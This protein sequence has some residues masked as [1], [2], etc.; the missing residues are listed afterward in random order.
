M[1]RQNQCG[2]LDDNE[3][4]KNLNTEYT[5]YRETETIKGTLYHRHIDRVYCDELFNGNKKL[6]SIWSSRN[7]LGEYTKSYD[8]SDE[9]YTDIVSSLRDI[10][11]LVNVVQI[12]LT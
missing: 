1:N 4:I 8:E 11:T 9:F 12:S 2:L 6:A 7:K 3:I 10:L 5:M